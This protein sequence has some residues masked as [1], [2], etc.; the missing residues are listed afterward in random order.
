VGIGTGLS[1]PS[2]PLHVSA[3][4]ANPVYVD[5][6]TRT[7]NSSFSFRAGTG[8]TSNQAILQVVAGSAANSRIYLGDHDAENQC[9]M[10]YNNSNE[11]F[12]LSVN[13]SSRMAV[14]EDGRFTF[15]TNAS[16]A[17]VGFVDVVANNGTIMC[18]GVRGH[19]LDNGTTDG[20]TQF[21]ISQSTVHKI[22]LDQDATFSVTNDRAGDRFMIRVLQDGSGGHSVTWW[23]TIKWAGNV[24]PTLSGANKADLLGFLC[25][26][27]NTYDGFIVGQDI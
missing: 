15:G 9:Q 22:T 10:W 19:L 21:D 5:A 16:P 7:G 13:G 1:G 24:T 8:A 17:S 2:Y 25:T 3:S 14:S 18:S 6:S 27:T 23:S 11:R 12:F 20:T 4:N 26:G